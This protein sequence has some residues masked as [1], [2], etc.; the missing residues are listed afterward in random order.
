MPESKKADR[1]QAVQAFDFEHDSL[2]AHLDDALEHVDAE[3]ED[4][5]HGDGSSPERLHVLRESIRSCHDVVYV[6]LEYDAK[7]KAEAKA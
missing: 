4:V 2:T 3:L 6:I 5:L 1:T 7:R